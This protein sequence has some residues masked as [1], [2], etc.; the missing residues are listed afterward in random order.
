MK[1]FH[2]IIITIILFLVHA[3]T[4]GPVEVIEIPERWIK[5]IFRNETASR[6]I[7]QADHYS[8]TSLYR[9][10]PFYK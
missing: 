5:I 3:A 2:L 8:Q 9:M 7:K 10:A 4:A 6:A 1:I